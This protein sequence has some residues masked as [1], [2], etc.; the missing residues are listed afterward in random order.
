MVEP[1]EGTEN[2]GLPITLCPSCAVQHYDI[3][4]IC[5]LCDKVAATGMQQRVDDADIIRWTCDTCGGVVMDEAAEIDDGEM[6]DEVSYPF[7]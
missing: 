2:G 1:L 4:H 5:C 3:Q 7:G 6:D